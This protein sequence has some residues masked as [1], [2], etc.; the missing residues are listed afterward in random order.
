M[1]TVVDEFRVIDCEGAMIS[2]EAS[3]LLAKVW[4]MGSLNLPQVAEF[5][6]DDGPEGH[7]LVSSLLAYLENFEG[8]L[9]RVTSYDV[10]IVTPENFSG[11]GKYLFYLA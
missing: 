1:T 4:G 10:L 7:A 2:E 8:H 3:E 11:A 6:I 5:Q 9:L